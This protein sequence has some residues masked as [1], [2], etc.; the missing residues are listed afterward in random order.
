MSSC[1]GI[2]PRK[3]VARSF[4]FVA[5]PDPLSPHQLSTMLG[6]AIYSIAT[7]VLAP[8]KRLTP[9]S[10][11]PPQL[12]GSSDT[13]ASFEFEREDHTLGNALRY[14][15]MKKYVFFA[16]AVAAPTNCASKETDRS[17]SFR[18]PASPDV[19]FCGYSIPHPSEA[20][21]NVR[22]QTYGEFRSDLHEQRRP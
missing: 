14:M 16:P 19:E 5:E 13:A 22:I 8:L 2:V 18:P 12:P 4:T 10:F 17:L 6:A 9:A 20:K 15:I 21:M 11:P 3:F 1:T 7:A